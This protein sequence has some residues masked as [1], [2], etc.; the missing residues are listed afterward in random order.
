MTF[1]SY[2]QYDTAD[3]YHYFAIGC[4]AG[5]VFATGGAALYF[6]IS[7]ASTTYSFWFNTGTESASGGGTRVEIKIDSTMSAQEVGYAVYAALSQYEMSRIRCVAAASVSQSSYFTF[8]IGSTEY[9]AWYSKDSAGV[10]PAVAGA[11][12]IQ[13]DIST[14]QTAAQIASATQAALNAAYYGVPDLRGVFLRGT[15]TA[16]V[17]DLDFASRFRY[18]PNISDPVAGSF[19]FDTIYSHYHGMPC[20]TDTSAG[21]YVQ[22]SSVSSVNNSTTAIGHDEVR[23]INA[24]VNYFIK[25]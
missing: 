20:S 12:G 8:Y 19:E 7:N 21:N 17:W 10:D 4:V 16:E 5:T 15:D 6:D 11:T 1:T 3:Q 25:Y 24:Y 18:A 14:G 9:Y 13:V 2:R 22:R 23:P